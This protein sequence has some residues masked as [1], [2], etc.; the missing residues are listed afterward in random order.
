MVGHFICD[1]CGYTWAQEE[2]DDGFYNGYSLPLCPVC[3]GF[4]CDA[5]DYEDFAC[6]YCGYRWRNYG[7]GGLVHGC[8][9]NC[10]KCGTSADKA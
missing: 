5:D 3:G 7:N 6:P 2:D 10:P 1:S 8:W 9:P 4:S